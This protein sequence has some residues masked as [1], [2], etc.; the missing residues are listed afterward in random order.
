[1]KQEENQIDKRDTAGIV[2]PPP[3]I[4]LAALGI[5]YF[6]SRV[7]PL[8]FVPTS[9]KMWG[10]P[11]IALG[12]LCMVSA[13]HAMQRANTP[14]D[15][16]QATTALVTT[17]VYSFSRNPLYITL[18][19]FYVGGALLLNAPWA[20]L[21]L[22]LVLMVMVRYVIVREE[23]Y[24]ERKFGAAYRQYKARVRRWI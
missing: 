6:F 5:G 4:Y 9:A 14:V 12:V 2:A 13:F 3:L 10:W 17:G 19:L 11:L 16:Y 23:R 7:Y 8:V 24:L 15:P 18:T 21:L 22:P 20:M 1:M